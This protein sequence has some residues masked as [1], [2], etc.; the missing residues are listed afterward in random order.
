MSVFSQN[1]V[2]VVARLL[3]ASVLPFFEVCL[4]RYVCMHD[5]LWPQSFVRWQLSDCLCSGEVQPRDTPRYGARWWKFDK[6]S[7]A[8]DLREALPPYRAVAS[9]GEI[10]SACDNGLLLHRCSGFRGMCG[11]PLRL[12]DRPKALVGIHAG[13]SGA[14]QF[15]HTVRWLH[16]H[17]F[18]GW[19]ALLPWPHM[20]HHGLVTDFR[21]ALHPQQI[22]K[23]IIN[24]APEH[25]ALTQT[26]AA[27]RSCSSVSSPG[28]PVGAIHQ[29]QDN[30]C[31]R[32]PFM[33]MQINSRRP[34]GAR[35]STTQSLCAGMRQR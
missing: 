22:Q 6:A 17:I 16:H 18:C 8:R 27:L 32:R 23:N 2:N 25:A 31:Q 19:L 10:L 29:L 35:P 20:M 21:H 14:P 5:L 24:A 3:Q 11:G 4:L 34:T 30:T 28:F 12:L 26:A 13:G 1:E 7:L 9:P 33:C 15:L